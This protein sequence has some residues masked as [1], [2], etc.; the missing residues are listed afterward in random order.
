M[1]R[2]DA[3]IPEG[4]DPVLGR[5]S[6]TVTP[7]KAHCSLNLHQECKELRQHAHIDLAMFR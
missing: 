5:E 6:E 1:F 4:D 2:E 7:D 3:E